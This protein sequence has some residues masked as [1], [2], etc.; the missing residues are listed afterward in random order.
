MGLLC[1]VLH[2]T[3]RRLARWRLVAVIA[4][5]VVIVGH[6]PRCVVM[7]K[8][9]IPRGILV[10]VCLPPGCVVFVEGRLPPG[11]LLRV[12]CRKSFRFVG[13]RGPIRQC[14]HRIFGVS[15]TTI[16]VPRLVV[17]GSCLLGVG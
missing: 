8:G 14:L 15:W 4:V 9:Q 11:N 17:A 1:Q 16:I 6:L 13:T 2:R 3:A 10:R 7:W 12:R 5:I